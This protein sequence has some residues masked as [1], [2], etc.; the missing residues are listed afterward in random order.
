MYNTLTDCA[1]SREMHTYLPV[2]IQQLL[3]QTTMILQYCMTS[4]MCVPHVAAEK[5]LKGGSSIGVLA[6]AK[7]G[8]DTMELM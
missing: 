7:T 3:Q 1:S 6:V 4:S 2:R 8:R 5:G